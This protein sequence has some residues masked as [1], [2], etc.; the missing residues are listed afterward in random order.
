MKFT[1]VSN[2]INHHQ[3]P[4]CEAMRSRLGSG[5]RFIQTEPMEEERRKMGWGVDLASLPYVSVLYG[6]G[7]EALESLIQDSDIALFGWT[8]REDLCQKR[9]EAGKP[10]IRESERLY[11]EGQWK[12]VSPRGLIRKHHDHTRWRDAEA[13]LLCNGAY[14]ASDFDI[15]R[16]YPGKKY[17]WGYF[18]DLRTY[19]DA[20]MKEMKKPDESGTVRILWAGRFLPLKHPS[21]RSG[22]RRRDGRGVKKARSG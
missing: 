16:A 9:L 17:R 2:Y 6:N 4:F 22:W 5:F 13:Y 3:I 12:A 14:V 11:R 8:D 7:R 10:V 18:P 15:I 21:P 20:Q 19:T 1:F